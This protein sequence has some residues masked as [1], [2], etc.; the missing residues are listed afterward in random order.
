MAIC[1]QMTLAVERCTRAVAL[2]YDPETRTSDVGPNYP[3]M[4]F[5]A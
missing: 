5:A 4:L 2:I 1:M 3:Q